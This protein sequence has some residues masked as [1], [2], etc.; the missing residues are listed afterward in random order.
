MHKWLQAFAYRQDIQWWVLI[1]AAIG[2][3][4]IAFI[5]ISSQSLKAATANPVKSL[6]SD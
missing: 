4:I 2:A 1:V 5:T 3:I 6:R